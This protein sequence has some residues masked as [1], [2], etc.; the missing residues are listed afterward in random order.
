[1]PITWIR[2]ANGKVPS[3]AASAAPADRRQR[4]VLGHDRDGRPRARARDRRAERCREAADA[5]LDPGA[6]LLEELGEPAV[7]LL[8]LE[9]ELR[10]VVD[11]VRQG[12]EVVGDAI[13]RPGDPL[14]Q[15]SV[16]RRAHFVLRNSS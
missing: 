2:P 13:D 14:L 16:T 9:A 11:L 5:A 10:I 15:V 3:A 1:V 4:V 6:V 8:F 12:L 7:R